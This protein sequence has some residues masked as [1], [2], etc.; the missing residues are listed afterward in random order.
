MDFLLVIIEKFFSTTVNCLEF[1]KT[2]EYRVT[3]R[4]SER[5]KQKIVHELPPSNTSGSGEAV[6]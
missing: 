5:S 3:C 1:G 6:P 4:P 2:K